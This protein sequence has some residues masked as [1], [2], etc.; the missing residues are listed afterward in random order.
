[1][2]LVG[3]AR[4][5]SGESFAERLVEA[6]F[7]VR[8]IRRWRSCDIAKLTQVGG[9]YSFFAQAGAEKVVR[10]IEPVANC[11]LAGAESMSD[12]RKRHAFYST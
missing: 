7:L 1:M 11:I 5:D 9:T 4:S 12:S 10:A 6:G 3:M 2:P 8:V